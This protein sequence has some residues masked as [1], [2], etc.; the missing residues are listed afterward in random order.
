VATQ[1]DRRL[2]AYDDR[3]VREYS[4]S[5]TGPEPAAQDF[6]L[7]IETFFFINRYTPQ[8]LKRSFHKNQGWVQ[9]TMG[10]EAM[11]LAGFGYVGVELLMVLGGVLT[12]LPALYLRRA[13]A[14]QFPL[15]VA[16]A[17]WMS[18]QCYMVLQQAALWPVFSIGSLRRL[19]LIAVFEIVLFGFNRALTGSRR[20]RPFAARTADGRTPRL[21]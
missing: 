2:T 3:L 18:L 6:T 12:A 1:D 21:A 16:L 4:T 17:L 9:L 7:G 19:L 5:L 14:S 15:S 20:A 13:M 10:S 8:P 11:A